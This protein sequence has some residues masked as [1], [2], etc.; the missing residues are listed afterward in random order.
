MFDLNADDGSVRKKK[1]NSPIPEA[2]AEGTKEV[3]AHSLDT[4]K[5][6][7]LHRRLMAMYITEQ[8][9]QHANRAEMAQEEDVY[10]NEQWNPEDV[11]V[12]ESR[13]Q[14]ALVYNVISA[15][16]DWIS[17]TEKRTRTDWKILPRRKEESKPA[18]RKTELMKYL[19]DTNKSEFSR[20]RAFEDAV[21]VGLGWMEDG[22]V[23]D[24]DGEPL[25]SRYENWRN[26]LHDSAGTEPDLTDARYVFRHKWFDIDVIEQ[27]FKERA[28]V[29]KEASQSAPGIN[30]LDELSDEITDQH[31][32]ELD[33]DKSVAGSS[34]TIGVYSRERVR[35]IEAWIRLPAETEKLK[36][37]LFSGEIYDPL[38]PAHEEAIASGD[39][40]IVK[41]PTMRMHVA[42][43]TTAGML[44]FGPSPYRHNQFPFTPIWGYRRGKN[45]LPYGLIRR[46][47]DI[48]FDVNKRASKALHILSSNKIIVEEGAV[49][50]INELAE[51]AARPDAVIVVKPGKQVKL[52]ADRD[53]AQG[54][55]EL[56]SRSISMIQQ[57]SGVTDEVL[58]RT[59]NAVSGRAIVARQEQ[60]SLATAKFF[61]NLM[62]A[63]QVR[64]EKVLVNM[65]QFM[66]EKK[67]FRITN[68]RGTPQFIDIN[69]GL[70]ENDIIRS[71]A[72]FVLSQQ[73]W[74]ATIRQANFAA[75]M[76]TI[77]KFPPEV[78][79]NL[80]DLVVET[81]DLPNVEELVAR[82]RQLNKQKDPDADPTEV[83]E[84]EL[85]R[86]QAE[87]K[88]Q[89]L[90]EENIAAE[91]RAKN[92]RASKDEA[93]AAAI[94]NKNV[95]SKVD[96]QA[97]ALA[98]ARTAV[99]APQTLPL[100]D[101]ILHESGFI[102]RTESEDGARDQLRA[103]QTQ[104]AADEQKQKA[105]QEIM[106]PADAAQPGTDPAQ[107]AEPPM[108][109]PQEMENAPQPAL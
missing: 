20:S 72:D 31:E 86:Q 84:E 41:R 10:D 82:I 17:G 58:G 33:N 43:F 108:A 88:A 27:I 93:Q 109:P 52:D 89:A 38:S 74:N 19:S 53:L 25:Y 12:L 59:T 45:N 104:A 26:I 42:I 97:K 76:D 70:P 1:Y 100:A 83:S 91:L 73:D 16:I 21:R 40:E 79:F 62:F 36:G 11:A 34:A 3:R 98:A 64:G 39:A 51:E 6:V 8:D 95:E 4:P 66:T 13:G 60:G 77:S 18:E 103:A 71:K 106:A 85:A 49:E 81:S 94:S 2:K 47:K 32:I 65:E 99:E 56:M 44:Y 61:D 101:N 96:A 50:D 102:S 69:D 9:R 24:T 68:K 48:Q 23:E 7:A 22:Y 87:A 14:T 37:G 78:S 90:Q 29:I 46:L 5:M 67:A 54:H 63:E 15:S 30:G 92:A 28:G 55:M 107:N 80:L 35:V 105:M 57:A 75:L